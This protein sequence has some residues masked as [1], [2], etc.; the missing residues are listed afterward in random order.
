MNVN[1][2]RRRK[3]LYICIIFLSVVCVILIVNNSSYAAVENSERTLCY[4][5]ILVQQG[6]SLWSIARENIT[7]EWKSI[8]EYVEVIKRFNT[9]DGENIFAGSYISIP[10]YE[11]LE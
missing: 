7:E 4:R 1:N 3:V 10:Y 2:Y 6:D 8:N 11:F 5:A 9:L